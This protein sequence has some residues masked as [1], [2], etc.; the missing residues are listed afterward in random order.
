M[1]EIGATLR[2]ARMR[3]AHRHHGDGGGRR[4]APSTCARSRTRSGTCCPGPTY[5]RSFLR[6]YADALG[7]DA[8]LLVEE[9]KL[10][11]E[12]G[13]GDLPPIA[14]GA[15][16]ARA[17][18]A[19]RA[20][21]APP[22]AAARCSSAGLLAALLAGLFVLGR[23]DDD[24][25]RARRATRAPAERHEPPAAGVRD[26]DDRADARALRV[27]A[28]GR[29]ADPRRRRAAAV[30]RIRASCARRRLRLTLGQRLGAPG[31]STASAASLPAGE[32]EPRLR[33]A[34]PSGLRRRRMPG[35]RPTVR[36]MSARAA[37]VSPAPRC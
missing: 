25:R 19:G 12:H 30:A 9:Y 18:G 27:R 22:R 3:A 35:S 33:G 6:T 17:R 16:A 26:A 8:R 20:A 21:A 11:H 13:E 15:P 36:V 34:R 31:R 32:S 5:V 1:P 4:S 29:R 24:D 37:I 2:E 7:L 28:R 23:G 14:K 10:R